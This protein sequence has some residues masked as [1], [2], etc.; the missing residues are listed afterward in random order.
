MA[1]LAGTRRVHCPT[2]AR[3]IRPIT[4]ADQQVLLAA[5]SAPTL[6]HNGRL[7]VSLSDTIC[8]PFHLPWLE[9]LPCDRPEKERS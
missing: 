3:G 8:P 2:P 1:G 9:R 7:W 5:F 4:G 6:A